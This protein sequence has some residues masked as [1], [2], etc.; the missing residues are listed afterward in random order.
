MSLH[1]D[2]IIDPKAPQPFLRRYQNELIFALCACV[3]IFLFMRVLVLGTDEGTLIDGAVR[4]AHGQVF[5]R[6][7]FEAMGP[8]TFYWLALF[9]KL[10]GITFVATRICLF[11]TSLGTVLAMLYLSRRVCKSYAFLPP[12][13]L[14]ATY[15]WVWPTISHHTDSNLFAL[16]SVVSI[17]RWLEVRRSSLLFLAGILAG[18]TTCFLQPKGVLLI[19]ALLIWLFIEHRWWWPH[20]VPASA[21]GFLVG[22]YIVA[23]GTVILYFSWQGALRDLIYANF[24]LPYRNYDA[25]NFVPYARGVIAYYWDVWSFKPGIGFVIGAILI[26]PYLLIA[27]LP[28]LLSISGIHW[29]RSFILPE[30]TLFWFCGWALW[31]SEIHRKDIIHL[32]FGSPLLIILIVYYAERLSAR[33]SKVVLQSLTIS[34]IC[35]AGYN[36]LFLLYTHPLQT[37]VGT[38][39]TFREEKLAKLLEQK[40]QPGEEIFTYPYCPIYYFL[41]ETINPTKYSFLMYHYNTTSQFKETVQILQRHRVRYVV[42]NRHFQDVAANRFFP[43][44]GKM[45]PTPQI[46]EP[47]LESHYRQ[48]WADENNRLMELKSD[49]TVLEKSSGP[50]NSK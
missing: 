37:R 48:I 31:L 47:Y 32:V 6:D 20:S 49:G 5:A 4:V 50:R 17:C 38:V 27:T 30:V 12:V 39:T 3:Y 1:V 25:V 9:F 33:V 10:F 14:I 28:G 22:G 35:L 34:A 7:F 18:L 26:L 44:A 21:F 45:D 11:V 24:T 42:W 29:R 15:C 43:S 40:T 8:G 23:T 19:A 13:L 41:T 36:L 46:I 2:K 16:L